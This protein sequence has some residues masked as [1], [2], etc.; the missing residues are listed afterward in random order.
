[1]ARPTYIIDD[2]LKEYATEKQAKYLDA[3]NKCRSKRKAAIHCGVSYST[4]NSSILCLL[5]KASIVGYSPEHMNTHPA[6][7]G[8]KV[9]GHSTLIDKRTGDAVLQWVKTTADAESQEAA[10]R[11]FINYLVED[12]KGLAP[13]TP[14]PEHTTDDLLCV[15][16][17]GDPHFGM[18]AWWQEAGDD[19]DLEI[20]ERLTC[21]AIDRLVASAP[22]AK[23][24]VLLNLGDMFHAD[25]QQNTSKSGHQLDVDGRWAKV[26]QIGL[27]SMIHCIRRLLEKH[28]SVVVR[29]NKGNHDGHSSY[30]LA[31]MVD[32][33]FNQ[34]PRVSVDLSPAEMWYYHFGN[35]LIGS[36]HGDRVKGPDMMSVMAAD[37][38]ESWGL[39]RHRYIYVGHVHHQDVK[40][41]RGGV[42]EYFRTLAARDAW[43]S[44]QGY[45]A[46]RDMRLIVHHRE[47]GEIERHRCDV[48][49]IS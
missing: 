11:E 41:Y 49:M 20:A 17:M 18:Y 47:F 32:A 25:N 43:H 22:P 24:A 16:P 5:K 4:L 33:Y 23:T 19:F 27:R 37:R 36:T 29:I 39:S 10:I 7:P 13:L 21:G 34:E 1:M 38:H 42:V 15:Y 48:A 31:L 35:V 3:I 44:G 40:E 45:R 14:P 8:F 2:K 26:Q 9:K 46:G 12:V 28:E 6:A 30:A